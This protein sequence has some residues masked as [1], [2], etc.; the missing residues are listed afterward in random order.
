ML[1]SSITSW[2]VMFYLYQPDYFV[3]KNG[4]IHLYTGT[5][6]KAD[7]ERVNTFAASIFNV[8]NQGA[9]LCFYC[10]W[11]CWLSCC[12]AFL[13]MSMTSLRRLT[14]PVTSGK[15][16]RL[17]SVFGTGGPSQKLKGNQNEHC[18]QTSVI[19]NNSLTS[20]LVQ[21]VQNQTVFLMGRFPWNPQNTLNYF[22]DYNDN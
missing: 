12:L 8:G 3:T 5:F 16:M 4:S 7:P 21:T 6:I 18:K 2:C 10:N 17:T 22:I 11:R 19:F 13:I 1:W 14:V 20:I 9:A 15:Q